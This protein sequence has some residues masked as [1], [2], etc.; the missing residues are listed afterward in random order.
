MPETSPTARICHHCDGFATVAIDTGT[1]TA[2]GTRLTLRVDC[3]TCHG[4]GTLPVHA[5]QLAGG[6]A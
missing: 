1:R 2:D 5:A 4:T 3:P 6:R